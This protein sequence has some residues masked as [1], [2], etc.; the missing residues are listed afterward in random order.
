MKALAV[1]YACLSAAILMGGCAVHERKPVQGPMAA[2]ESSDR[3]KILAVSPPVE[4][5]LH[6]GDRVRLE[7]EVEYE[8]S[9]TRTATIVLVVQRAEDEYHPLANE[10]REVERGIGQVLLTAEVEVPETTAL[11][12]LTPLTPA[13]ARR[14]RIVQSR[15]YA[16]TRR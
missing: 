8:L 14:T 7:V 10:R 3:V 4:T 9:T 2:S 11:R 6:P 13:G 12:V 15:T 16:V 5:V 1:R